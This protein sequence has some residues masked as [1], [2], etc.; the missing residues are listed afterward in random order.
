MFDSNTPIMFR[1]R[2]IRKDRD[3]GGVATLRIF[4]LDQGCRAVAK[5][6]DVRLFTW[7]GKLEGYQQSVLEQLEGL[8]SVHVQVL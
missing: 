7:G 4:Q 6:M 2:Q 3:D 1:T 5:D 8:H